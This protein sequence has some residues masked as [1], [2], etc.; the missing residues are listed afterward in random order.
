LA[1]ALALL[2]RLDEA[3]AAAEA[4]L[5]LNPT[6]SISRIR[7][8]WTARSDNPTFLAGAGRILEGLRKAG[9]PER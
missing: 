8:G 4:G 9:L 7:A 6:Q 3:H 2:G 5:G 1:A